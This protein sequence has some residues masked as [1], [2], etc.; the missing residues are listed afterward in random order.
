MVIAKVNAINSS[1]VLNEGDFLK[2]MAEMKSKVASAQQIKD[3]L[4]VFDTSPDKN[5]SVD[6][7]QLTRALTTMGMLVI[8]NNFASTPCLKCCVKMY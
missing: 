7:K 8:T 2:F 3:A 1:G 6:S 5:G 4:S